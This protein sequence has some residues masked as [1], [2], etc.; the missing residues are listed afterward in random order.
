MLL[1]LLPHMHLSQFGTC[2]LTG[3]MPWSRIFGSLSA[4]SNSACRSMIPD[5]DNAPANNDF[6]IARKLQCISELVPDRAMRQ[7][8]VTCIS[9]SMQLAR[10]PAYGY[11]FIACSILSSEWCKVGMPTK[12]LPGLSVSCTVLAR[13]LRIHAVAASLATTPAELQ[14]QALQK[15]INAVHRTSQCQH[16]VPRYALLP[17]NECP[18]LNSRL[19]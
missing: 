13:A 4:A 1:P 8:N 19:V 2:L 17:A 15:A 5:N 10:K 12:Y 18:C 7:M 11:P 3:S 9:K 14:H 6:Y 16:H